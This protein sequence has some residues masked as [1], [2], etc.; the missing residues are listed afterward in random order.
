MLEESIPSFVCGVEFRKLM[1][2]KAGRHAVSM[3]MPLQPLLEVTRLALGVPA[4]FGQ[5]QVMSSLSKLSS[6]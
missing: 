5:N 3:E 6:R 4:S 1:L 2:S